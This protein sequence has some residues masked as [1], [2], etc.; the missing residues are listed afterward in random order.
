MTKMKTRKAM[1]KRFKV[2]ASGKL[3]KTHPGRRHIL[4]KKSAKRKRSLAKADYVHSGQET[5]IRNLMGGKNKRSKIKKRMAKER[6]A[7]LCD[8]SCS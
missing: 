4:T 6:A 1:K 3:K 5:M 2:T 8:L 7:L